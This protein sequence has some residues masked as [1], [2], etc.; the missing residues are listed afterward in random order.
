M[1]S[2]LRGK[3]MTFNHLFDIGFEVISKQENPSNVSDQELRNALMQRIA[4]MNDDEFR[5]A[6]NYCGDSYEVEG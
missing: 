3:A 5:E 6:C 2:M 4:S 1:S